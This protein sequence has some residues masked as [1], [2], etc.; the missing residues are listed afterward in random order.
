MNIS[1]EPVLVVR[2]LTIAY[3][4]ARRSTPFVAVDGIDF[5]IRRGES[6]GLVGESGCGKSSTAAS[7]VGLLAATSGSVRFDGVELAGRRR[8]AEI[9]RRI[10]VVLQD[11]SGALNPRMRVSEMLG[12]LVRVRRRMGKT[13]Y[14]APV[15]LRVRQLLE[16][17]ELSPTLLERYPRDLSGGQ[18]QRVSIARALALE[19]ELIVLD[20]AISALDMSV[21]AAVLSLLSRLRAELGTSYLFISHNLGAVRHLCERT[22]VMRAGRIVEIGDTEQI[23]SAPSHP[24]SRALIE[25]T[26]SLYLG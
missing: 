2:N 24:Y 13:A 15:P 21:Q 23:W 12:E 10:Q 18:R 11:P 19:P 14:P 16:L 3:P 20:E 9:K 25:A 8:S 4:G 26:P 7:V 6:L 17:V 1:N 5:D 22:A